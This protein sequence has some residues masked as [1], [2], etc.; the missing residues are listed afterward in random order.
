MSP[1]SSADATPSGALQDAVGARRRDLEEVLSREREGART[2][3]EALRE[4]AGGP[5]RIRN[6]LKPVSRRIWD[7]VFRTQSWVERGDRLRRALHFGNPA[8]FKLFLVIA[9]IGGALHYFGVFSSLTW[10]LH[11]PALLPGPDS[12]ALTPVYALIPVYVG[13]VLLSFRIM[14]ALEMRS[15]KRRLGVLQ[16]NGA[17]RLVYIGQRQRGGTAPS[18]GL[19][20]PSP[21][22]EGLQRFRWN[23]NRSY[24]DQ[25][26]LSLWTAGAEPAACY[27]FPFGEEKAAHTDGTIRGLCEHL[28]VLEA[29]S[30]RAAE[31]LE[32]QAGEMRRMCRLLHAQ[33][34][35][36]GNVK[37]YE[38]K[39]ADLERKERVWESIVLPEET[40]SAILSRAMLFA[41][42]SPAAPKGT[43]LYGPPGTGKSLLAKRLSESSDSHFITLSLPDLKADHVGGSGQA[44]RRIWKEARG[45]RRCVLFIDECEGVFGTR[46][47]VQTDRFGAEIVQAFLA[48]WDGI[49]GND[50]VWV[51]G[52]TNRR[53]LIDPAILSRF[54]DELM[55][56]LP[57][58][59]GRRRILRMELEKLGLRSA[60]PEMAVSTTAGFSGRDL[61]NLARDVY[62]QAYGKGAV[63]EVHFRIAIQKR[64]GKGG[65]TVDSSA[66]WD[67]LVLA[68]DVKQQLRTM[69][70]ML[71]NAEALTAQG[72]EIPRGLLLFGPPGTGKTQIARTI[73]NES[74]LQFVG[75]G[76]A[77]LKAGF[78]GQSGQKVRELF[79]RARASAPAIVFIDEIDVVAPARG[80]RSMED[81]FTREIVAQ[82]LQELDGIKRSNAHVFVIAASNF[83]DAIDSAILSRFSQRQEIPLPGEQQRA[84]I[85]RIL[86]RRKPIAGDPGTLAKA[87]AARTDGKSGRDL[88]SLVGNAEQRAV[89]RA[90]SQGHPDRIHLRAEDFG[91]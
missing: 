38:S 45:H 48:E 14:G 67:T 21:G 11:L 74:T 31:S 23:R 50:S 81:T 58:N 6:A 54:G 63:S 42:G 43:L 29:V 44:V 68:P 87:L 82:L 16:D 86:L 12:L 46:G 30:A 59:E 64:R 39:L 3:R 80:S 37:R 20:S 24:S 77:D 91:T 27:L 17:F 75:A 52:A 83:P 88:R 9:A 51:I 89:M 8:L 57:D 25:V 28:G 62:A 41:D 47:G 13:G 66:T 90:I 22:E 65:T 55:I 18:N 19:A 49:A 85:I 40:L 33:E 56:A 15:R 72:I 4:H 78:V 10:T 35:I 7:S 1:A 36:E 53:D 73:A 79:D 60:A 2:V 69:C 26:F 70:A 61:H 71:Q 84:A 34:D 32:A 5:R 76:T